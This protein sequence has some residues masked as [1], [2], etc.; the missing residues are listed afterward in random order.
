MGLFS[1]AEISNKPKIMMIQW[2]CL[3]KQRFLTSPKYD[4]PMGLFRHAEMPN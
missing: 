2:D 3:V 1:Y 4:S